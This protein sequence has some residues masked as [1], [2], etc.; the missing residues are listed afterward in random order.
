MALRVVLVDEVDDVVAD[1]V[2]GD[3]VRAQDRVEPLG[4]RLA[5][6]PAVAGG[7][8]VD[9]Q[10]GQ[11]GDV[12]AV[13]GE[14]VPGGELADLLARLQAGQAGLDS[15]ASAA[16]LLGHAASSGGACGASTT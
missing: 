10:G 8:V 1:E 12:A 3:A 2:E 9:E 14:R 5:A 16:I 11:V 7:D 13:E 6:H 4:Q 15:A